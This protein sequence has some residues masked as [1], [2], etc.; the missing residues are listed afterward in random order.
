[1][2]EQ[3]SNLILSALSQQFTEDDITVQVD[4]YRLEE[5]DGWTLEVIDEDDISFVYEDLFETDQEA[6]NAFLADVEEYGLADIIDP[7]EDEDDEA[8]SYH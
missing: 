8:P 4:I 6:W 2:T 1:M 7:D 3:D 5:E